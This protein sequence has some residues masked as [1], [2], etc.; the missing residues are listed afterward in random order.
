MQPYLLALESPLS[1]VTEPQD[2][3]IG[4]RSYVIDSTACDRHLTYSG[5]KGVRDD[6]EGNLAKVLSGHLW[7]ACARPGLTYRSYGLHGTRG[8]PA[9]AA[10]KE[11]RSSRL[12]GHYCLAHTTDRQ[13]LSPT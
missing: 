6:D 13:S 8:E 11:T 5:R 1:V 7:D 10:K 9:T 4:K 12:V 3:T 2:R